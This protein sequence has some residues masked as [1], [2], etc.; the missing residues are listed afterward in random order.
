MSGSYAGILHQCDTGD[1]KFLDGAS[2]DLA[3][4]RS[5]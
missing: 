1:A 2:I 4:N 5:G 3:Q